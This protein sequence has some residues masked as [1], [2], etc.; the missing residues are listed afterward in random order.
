MAGTRTK[1][2][3]Q[4]AKT[5]HVT[6]ERSARLFSSEFLEDLTLEEL[7][8]R[9]DM[10]VHDGDLKIAYACASAIDRKRGLYK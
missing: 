1:K 8:A 4:L 5:S 7:R 6:S 9:R 2:K 3:R 10:A